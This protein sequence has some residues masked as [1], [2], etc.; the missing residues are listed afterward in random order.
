VFF[1]IENLSTNLKD[2]SENTAKSGTLGHK[3]RQSDLRKLLS[4][5]MS[6]ISQR[7]RSCSGKPDGE[8]CEPGRPKKEYNKLNDAIGDFDF[9]KYITA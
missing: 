7:L 9:F 3:E 6:P 5:T 2:W 4:G 8:H 1:D